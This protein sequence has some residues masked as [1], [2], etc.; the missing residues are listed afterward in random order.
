M[1]ATSGKCSDDQANRVEGGANGEQHVG[2]EGR[3]K[4]GWEAREKA[5]GP[6]DDEKGSN[7]TNAIQTLARCVPR[8][9]GEDCLALVHGKRVAMPQRSAT[10]EPRGA[11]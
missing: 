11:R 3:E 6:G 5:D 10:A 4:D 8:A 1:P 9:F 7:P 2:N